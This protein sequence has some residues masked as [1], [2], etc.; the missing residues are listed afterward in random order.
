[1]PTQK[2]KIYKLSIYTCLI[3][4]AT[5]LPGEVVRYT[6][7][8]NTSQVSSDTVT[9]EIYTTTDT[10]GGS[11]AEYVVVMPTEVCI[12]QPFDILYTIRNNNPF[13]YFPVEWADLIPLN[14]GV[15]FLSNTT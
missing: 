7:S 11:N 5:M 15:T 9:R 8:T 10:L 4:F 2:N 13:E 1:M 3:L 14:Q 6:F 12:N